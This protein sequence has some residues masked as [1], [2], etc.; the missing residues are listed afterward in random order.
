VHL[1]PFVAE[2]R[3]AQHLA[4]EADALV[5]ALDFSPGNKTQM[6]TLFSSKLAEYTRTGLPIIVIGPSYAETVRWA[7]AQHCFCVV[8]DQSTD[9]VER[10]LQPL[11]RDD[12]L[13]REMGRRAQEIGRQAFAVERGV[14]QLLGACGM[15]R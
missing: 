9:A 11:F 14:E 15:R 6:A 12:C 13:R 7:R 2:E 1:Q 5:V 8:E 10:A 4:T 3:L